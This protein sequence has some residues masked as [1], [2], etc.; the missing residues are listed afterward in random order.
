M[1]TLTTPQLTPVADA[2]DAAENFDTVIL[3]AGISG[4]TLAHDF[5]KAGQSVLLADTYDTPGGNHI[6]VDIDGRSF[7]IGA[8][9]FWSGYPQFEMFPELERLVVPVTWSLQRVTPIGK[10]ARYPVDLRADLMDKPV[11]EWVGMAL[12]IAQARIRGNRRDNSLSFLRYYLG[13][14]LM[15]DSGILNYVERFYGLPADQI[16]YDFARSRMRTIKET[17]SLTGFAS[18]TFRRVFAENQHLAHE[19]CLARPK[20]GFANYYQTAIE[21]LCKMGVRIQL[22]ARIDWDAS[23]TRDSRLRIDGQPVKAATPISTMPLETTAD[24]IGI[25][26]QTAPRSKGLCT[27]FCQFRGRRGFDAMILYNFHAAGRWKRLTMHSDYYG[28]ED[29]WEYF[30]VEVTS[31]E[32]EHAEALFADFRST[33]RAFGLFDGDLELMGH[34]HTGFAYP[35]YDRDAA[36]KR[37]AMIEQINHAGLGLAGRQGRFQYLPTSSETIRTVRAQNPPS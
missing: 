22:G 34:R 30:S 28:P 5:A 7:D 16:S 33:A 6:S 9:F 36:S 10:V 14:K 12:Q 2:P 4:L 29:G 37:D 31:D 25:T 26:S 13:D 27:L 21:Q 3:G 35:V 11:G 24:L 20:S 32:A 17:A 18:K 8:I 15:Q 1:E 23:A 19:Q